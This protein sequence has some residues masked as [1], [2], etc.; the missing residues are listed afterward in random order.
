MGE[1]K[2]RRLVFGAACS[3]GFAAA[4]LST[5]AVLVGH[6][7]HYAPKRTGRDLVFRKDCVAD[8]GEP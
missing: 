6:D 1:I 8:M 7:G 4:F 2:P 3:V 5:R